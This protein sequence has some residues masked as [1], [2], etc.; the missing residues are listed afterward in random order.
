MRLPSRSMLLLL[1]PTVASALTATR[2][3]ALLKSLF[4]NTVDAN[5]VAAACSPTVTWNDM[6]LK[7]PLLG[8]SAVAEHLESLHPP[9][10][11]LVIE[12]CADG[13]QKSGF[14]WHREADGVDGM[15]LRGITYVEL[16]DA[17]QISFVQEGSE[18]IFKLDKLLEF[19]L[20]ATAKAIKEDPNK[21]PPT[22]ERANPTTA[23]DIV[24]YLWEVAYPGG[25]TPQEA[26]TFFAD[27]IVYEDFNYRQPFVGLDAVSAYIN[28]LPDF[29]NFVFVPEKI[30]QGKVGCCLTWKVV[31]NGEDGPSGI[32]FNE[33]NPDGK[34]CFARDIPAPSGSAPLGSLAGKLRPKL[35][36]FRARSPSMV[37]TAPEEEREETIG[38]T[39]SRP[40]R[41]AMAAAWIGFSVYVAAFSPGEFDVSPDSFDNKL[42]ANAIA[43]PTSLN[44]IFFAVFNAL[45][46][47]P[48][49]NAALLLPGSKDQK[50]LPALPFVVSSFALGFG[51]IGPYLTFREPRPEVVKRSELGFFSRYVTESKLYGAGLLVASLILA[52]GLASIGD[53]TAAS[54]EFGELFASSKLVHVSTIDLCVLSAFAF[55]PIREDMARR[56]WWD[57]DSE[58]NN[59]ARLLG[60]C[61]PVV[62][63]CAYLIARPGLEE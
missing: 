14:C 28:L 3:D 4:S 21:P 55:E 2:C 50:P 34:I 20:T 26:L 1:L 18:P 43:D 29:P 31:V 38:Q 16:D 58:D 60:F 7:E 5:A 62:G 37:A 44:P 13:E 56:G 41:A 51:G 22:F 49:V 17:G 48:G 36:R 47:I 8:P 32:S 15:G 35:R 57:V 46:V 45:G 10:S 61:L 23:E 12:R 52:Q 30:S 39:L 25:A 11:K 6:S 63:P 40:S 27:E 42:I 54:T 19:I 9:G 59:V 53:Y 24:K 33:V